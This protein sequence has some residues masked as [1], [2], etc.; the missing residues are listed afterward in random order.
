MDVDWDK[1]FPAK[2]SEDDQR[3]AQWIQKYIPWL[4]VG[5]NKLSTKQ[6]KELK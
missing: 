1:L 3:A 4:K 6:K 2:S 5:C